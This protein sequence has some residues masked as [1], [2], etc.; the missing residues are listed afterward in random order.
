MSSFLPGRFLN[1]KE[2]CSLL[3]S[4]WKL[5]WK[6]NQSS[7]YRRRELKYR[8]KVKCADFKLWV[9]Q[10]GIFVFYF[11]LVVRATFA[12][13]Q[14]VT[15][16]WRKTFQSFTKK[17]CL[18]SIFREFVMLIW[19]YNQFWQQIKQFITTIVCRNIAIW[20]KNASTSHQIREIYRRWKGKKVDTFVSWIK[21]KIR[22]ILLLV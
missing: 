16:L 8:T 3:S 17:D 2:I 20:N 18:V 4:C 22:F 11:R 7:S 10:I 13:A 1:N 21:R 15:R 5:V 19:T 6:I 12:K 14:M 9:I